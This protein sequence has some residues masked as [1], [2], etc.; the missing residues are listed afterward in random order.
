MDD[1]TVEL[2]LLRIATGQPTNPLAAVVRLRPLEGGADGRFGE[3]L[4]AAA[5]RVPGAGR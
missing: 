3:L 1:L 4:E 5:D 2:C